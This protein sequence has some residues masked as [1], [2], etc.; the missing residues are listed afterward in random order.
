MFILQDLR[1]DIE[2]KTL[3]ETESKSVENSYLSSSWNNLNLLL[4]LRTQ[5]ELL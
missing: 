1:H 2:H 4:Q 3:A 5:K